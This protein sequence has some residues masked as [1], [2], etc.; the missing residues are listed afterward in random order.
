MESLINIKS[1]TNSKVKILNFVH[2]NK[3]DDIG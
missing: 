2:V 3:S 1:N